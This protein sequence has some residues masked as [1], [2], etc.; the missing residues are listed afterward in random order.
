LL[1][2]KER[3][4]LNFKHS[5]NL[6][7]IALKTDLNSFMLTDTIYKID[8]SFK[9]SH[10]DNSIPTVYKLVRLN[11]KKINMVLFLAKNLA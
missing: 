4:I 5:K 9:I 2:V 1:Q 6:F 8:F 10:K 7:S 11:L 3:K